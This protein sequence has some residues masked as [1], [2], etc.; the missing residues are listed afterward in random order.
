MGET[1]PGRNPAT[2]PGFPPQ[3]GGWREEPMGSFVSLACPRRRRC[4][5]RGVAFGAGQRR[6]E[7]ARARRSVLFATRSFAASAV[8]SRKTARS[9]AG[10][11]RCSAPI[12]SVA[13]LAADGLGCGLGDFARGPRSVAIGVS[14]G[15]G[16]IRDRGSAPISRGLRWAATARRQWPGRFPVDPWPVTAD[17]GKPATTA[18]QVLGWGGVKPSRLQDDHGGPGRTRRPA[19]ARCDRSRE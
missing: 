6:Q 18:E 4:P 1:R 5:V 17:G 13:E 16:P 12:S 14:R 19:A 8:L 10:R 2:P 15:L 3:K 11:D 9:G 7:N